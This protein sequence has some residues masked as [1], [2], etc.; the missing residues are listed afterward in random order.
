MSRGN[1]RL[2]NDTQRTARTS[3]CEISLPCIHISH[4]HPSLR[5]RLASS[6]PCT[7]RSPTAARRLAGGGCRVV[8]PPVAAVLFG[9]GCRSDTCALVAQATSP[10]RETLARASLARA[11]SPRARPPSEEMSGNEPMSP[12]DFVD[13]VVGLAVAAPVGRLEGR[14]G[15]CA[16]ADSGMARENRHSNALPFVTCP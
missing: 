15:P 7:Q 9:R 16:A 8:L 4:E 5:A 12:T 3:K 10:V 1:E 6:R 14:G 13:V 11:R 2:K